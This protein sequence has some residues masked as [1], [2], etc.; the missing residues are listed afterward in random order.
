M[1]S[2]SDVVRYVA[3]QL[4]ASPL[5]VA[6]AWLLKRSG[7]IIPIPGTASVEHLEENIVAAML[8]LP[9]P[10]FEALSAVQPAYV[11]LLD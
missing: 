11:N 2:L 7:V 1:R 4:Y 6:R 3:G 8:E 5:Q 10:A 9:E